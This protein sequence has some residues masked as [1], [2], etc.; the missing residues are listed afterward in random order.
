MQ[1]TTD[2]NQSRPTVRVKNTG[3]VPSCMTRPDIV[4]AKRAFYTSD[5]FTWL[6]PGETKEISVYVLWWEPNPP[7][8]LTL[9]AWN[10]PVQSIKLF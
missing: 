4:G 9:G 1:V 7:A 10:A 2:A 5:N 8:V 3:T 6:A